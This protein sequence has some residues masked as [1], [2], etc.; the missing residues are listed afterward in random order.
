MISIIIPTY[1]R[2]AALQRC[3]DTILPQAFEGLEVIVIDDCSE[4]DTADYLR[5]LA[6]RYL[7]IRIILNEKN[8]GVNYSRNRGIEMAT[9]KYIFFLDSDDELIPG[10]LLKVK[11]TLET[12]PDKK[13]FLFLVSDREDEFK[14]L[15]RV[16][17]VAYSSWLN[18][19][20][21]GD[22]AHVLLT[23]VM[24]KYLFFEEFRMF[25]HLNWLRIKKETDPQLLVPIVVTVRERDRAD[26]LT[27]NSRLQSVSVIR[28][29]F[30]SEKMYYSMYHEDL[31]RYSP[32]SLK[33]QLIYTMALG[34]AVNQKPASR[35]LLNYANETHIKVIGSLL[36]LIPSSLLKY[37][38]IKYST[39]KNR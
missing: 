30:E 11:Q 28:T 22:Y 26:S 34:A 13:H 21:T 24:K 39:L 10:G 14:S 5:K 27:L 32:K 37:G 36:M 35:T 25:E 20:T 17:D 33:Y 23:S 1:K 7:F 19:T 16:K 6:D 12:F 2:L 18:G 9:G 4:D 3:I 8:H 29:K 38:I 15:E 31:G